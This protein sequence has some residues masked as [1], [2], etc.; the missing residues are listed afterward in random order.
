M[1]QNICEYLRREAVQNLFNAKT[2]RQSWDKAWRDEINSKIQHLTAS[3][4]VD[5][6]DSLGSIFRLTGASGRSQSDVSGG[7]NAWEALVCWYL[8]I[9]LIGSRTVVIKQNKNLVPDPVRQALTVSYGNF[10]S[11]TESDLIAITFPNKPCYT[12][13]KD[14]IF[15]RDNNGKVVSLYFG[16]KEKKFNYIP[17]INLLSER[18]FSDFEIGVI[19][20]KTNWNDN[21]QIPMLWDMIYS[22]SSFSRSSISVGSSTFKIDY[23]QR[24]T[25]SFVTVPTVN[26]QKISSTS[27]CVKR[28]HNLS[29]GN[30]W[31]YP[32]SP[33]IAN[34]IKD[35]F[36]KNFTSASSQS[37]VNRL[38]TELKHLKTRYSYFN[39]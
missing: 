7:G 18:D 26:R 1:A 38:N 11:G 12:E 28:V 8:N 37:L 33:S 31:G 27:T 3:N 2:F 6:G 23:L 14:K 5:I 20:C 24:F 10:P 29:G 16:K 22:T 34:S 4:V 9:C 17:I 21:A 30:Y 36:G 19:Q 13:D 25:Y 15:I 35:I 39:L 32:A